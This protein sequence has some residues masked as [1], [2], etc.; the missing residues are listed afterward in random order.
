MR[1]SNPS[2]RPQKSNSRGLG[3]QFLDNLL[4]QRSA[5]GRQDHER[6]G[7]AIC[8]TA[9][10]ALDHRLDLQDHARAAA[11]RSIIDLVMF[12]ARPAGGCRAT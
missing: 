2:Y 9:L 1:S 7:S 3:G 8:C 6:P 5:A 4:I 11:E 12:V 10:D